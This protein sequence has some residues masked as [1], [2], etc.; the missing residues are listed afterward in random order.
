MFNL[1][2]ALTTRDVAV[3]L[4]VSP[5]EVARRV[6]R[7]VLEPVV[8]LPGVRGAYLF[9]PASIEALKAGDRA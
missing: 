7:G 9:D 3:A 2:D 5:R 8:K 6:Q 1:D 4:G